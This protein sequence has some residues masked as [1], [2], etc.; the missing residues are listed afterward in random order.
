MFSNGIEA[1]VYV[2]NLFDSHPILN[3]NRDLIDITT[4][5][6]SIQPRTIGAEFTYHLQ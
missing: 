6:Y 3:W 4:G 5:A 2:D 1:A